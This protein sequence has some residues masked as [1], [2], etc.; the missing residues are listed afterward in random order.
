MDSWS[1]T[2]SLI[3]LM[4]VIAIFYVVGRLVAGML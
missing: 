1:E 3:V 2:A 4:A